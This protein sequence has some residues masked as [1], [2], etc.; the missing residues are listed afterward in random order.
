MLGQWG[1]GQDA[2]GEPD[3]STLPLEACTEVTISQSACVVVTVSS[4]NGVEV[5]VGECQCS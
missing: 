1:F 3:I 4:C 2:L 5:E